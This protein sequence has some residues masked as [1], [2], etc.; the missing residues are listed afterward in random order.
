MKLSKY[1]LFILMQC[2]C[3]SMVDDPDIQSSFKKLSKKGLIEKPWAYYPG[4]TKD[5]SKLVANI[6]KHVNK[7]QC[8]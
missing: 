2:Y 4:I 5:G 8:G 3:Y 7:A 1:D 6:L